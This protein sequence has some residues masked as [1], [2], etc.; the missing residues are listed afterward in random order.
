MI[1]RKNVPDRREIFLQP[2]PGKRYVRSFFFAHKINAPFSHIHLIPRT[3]LVLCL[4]SLELRA[5]DA[6]QPDLVT[7]L[8]LWVAC[9]SIFACSG[10]HARVA[11]V[12]L[13]LSIPTLLSLF[14]TWLLFN[15]VPGSVT[16]WKAQIYTGTITFGLA[17]WQAIWLTLVV[18][19]FWR[20]HTLV[21]GIL[22][23]TVTA[24]I[25]TRLVPLPQWT[26]ASVPFF[27]A[28]TV[29]ISNQNLLIAV[30]KVVGYSGMVFATIS[31]VVSSRDVEL[32]GTMRQFHLPQPV[33]FFLSTVF[34]TL[35]L[36]L[37]DYETIHQAQLARAIN[38][39]PRSSIKRLND[40]AGVAVPMVAV[41]IRRSS[42]IGDALIARGYRL[43]SSSTDFYE[44]SAWHWID[45]LTF[46]VCLGLLVLTF[47]PHLNLT[48]LL[49]RGWK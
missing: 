31:L 45:G 29:R 43:K 28:L 26:F 22:L 15:P 13:L 49:Q 20:T 12:Y 7:A 44:T 36:S 6:A 40:L 10:M 27:H 11:R 2:P 9:V 8:C 38:A 42:E 25:L 46:V 18:L 14:T 21:G 41:M 32:I 37:A 23:A 30:T 39:R 35:D 33:I 3:L 34:R 24:L 17:P 19:F 48:L 47:G 16:V 1:L 5:I 4:S